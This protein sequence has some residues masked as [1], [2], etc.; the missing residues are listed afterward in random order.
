MKL[1]SSI[2]PHNEGMKLDSSIYPHN[3]RMKLDSSIDSSI[4][5]HT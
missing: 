5:P 2:Y 3:E 4:A 1:D